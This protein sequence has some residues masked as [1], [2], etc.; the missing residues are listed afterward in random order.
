MMK[1]LRDLCLKV[2]F[3]LKQHVW[4]EITLVSFWNNGFVELWHNNSYLRIPLD[5]QYHVAKQLFTTNEN[6]EGQQFFFIDNC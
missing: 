2:N 4:Y 1:E 3:K 5:I 6:V